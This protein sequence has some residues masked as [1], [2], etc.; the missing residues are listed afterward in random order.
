MIGSFIRSLVVRAPPKAPAGAPGTPTPRLY[1]TESEASAHAIRPKTATPTTGPV[2]GVA[3]ES[4]YYVVVVVVPFVVAT[5][6]TQ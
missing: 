6:M 2:A 5:T 4:T 3:S 1:R